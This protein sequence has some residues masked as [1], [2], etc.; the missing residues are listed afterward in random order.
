MISFRHLTTGFLVSLSLLRMFEAGA[1]AQTLTWTGAQSGGPSGATIW[2]S[3]DNWSENGGISP[4]A[5]G[6][7]NPTQFGTVAGGASKIVT[8]LTTNDQAQ[9][10][11]FL[12]GATDFTFRTDNTLV[13]LPRL[14]IAGTTANGALVNLSSNRQTFELGLDFVG[15]SRTISNAVG[16]GG[17]TFNSSVANTGN[18]LTVNN[19]NSAA[20]GAVTFNSTV[21]ANSVALS[22]GGTT[23]FANGVS[24]GVSVGSGSR[25]EAVGSITGTTSVNG[26]TYSAGLAGLSNGIGAS[27]HTGGL[28]FGANSTFVW[29][30]SA[31][32]GSDSFDTVSVGGPGLSIGSNFSTVINLVGGQFVGLNDTWQVFTSSNPIVGLAGTAISV[33]GNNPNGHLFQWSV[34]GNVASITAVPEPS[35]MALLGIAGLIG[36]V[37]ARRRA[38][39]NKA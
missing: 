15:G 13:P 23:R 9:S 24:G 36:G 20:S 25:M 2:S 1:T 27:T 6:S 8:S 35:S 37:Y 21:Q 29:D 31:T 34:N 32:A 39:K 11:T 30:L 17:F 4:I 19:A 26:G 12:A 10:V 3:P 18:T 28:S 5:P 38:K 14:T 22:G 7:S 16:S 33:I